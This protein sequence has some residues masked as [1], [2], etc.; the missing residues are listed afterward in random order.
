[1]AWAVSAESWR[2]TRSSLG[3]KRFLL[4]SFPACGL[5]MPMLFIP[6]ETSDF[7]LTK[8]SG[9]SF[10]NERKFFFSR[11][12]DGLSTI[13]RYRL[14]FSD[15]ENNSEVVNSSLLA[16]L[17]SNKFFEKTFPSFSLFLA[18]SHLNSYLSSWS[19]RV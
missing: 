1:M 14:R 13:F 8:G 18:S 4:G 5:E 16:N 19:S 6:L 3:W 17:L 2:P 15:G 7:S 11:R 10:E 12:Q 9:T